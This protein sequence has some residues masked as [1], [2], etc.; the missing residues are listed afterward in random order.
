MNE[1]DQIVERKSNLPTP[2]RFQMAGKLSDL[3]AKTTDLDEPEHQEAMELGLSLGTTVDD[4]SKARRE[5]SSLA[6]QAISKP[7]LLGQVSV[8]MPPINDREVSKRLTQVASLPVDLNLAQ[9]KELYTY[10]FTLGVSSDEL[11]KIRGEL[12]SGSRKAI[13]G[14][15]I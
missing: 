1:Q 10:G 6:I 8:S 5:L 2:E 15:G 9:A 13:K 14:T 7:E 12:S 11:S 3:M 4:M